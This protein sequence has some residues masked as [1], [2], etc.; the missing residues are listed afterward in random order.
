LGDRIQHSETAQCVGLQ[1]ACTGGSS[2]RRVKNQTI[3]FPLHVLGTNLGGWTVGCAPDSTTETLSNNVEVS[4]EP[5]ELQGSQSANMLSAST[6]NIE[7]IEGVSIKSGLLSDLIDLEKYHYIGFDGSD[8]LIIRQYDDFI[9]KKVSI[10]TGETT[11]IMDIST[12]KNHFIMAEI[13]ADDWVIW[14]ESFDRELH[15]G[16]STGDDWAIYAANIETKQ[17]IEIDSEKESFPKDRDFNAQPFAMSAKGNT[18][19]YTCYDSDES[20]VYIAIKLFDF[21]TEERRVII[22]QDD[23]SR[24][25]SMPSVGNNCVVFSDSLLKD[26]MRQDNIIYTYNLDDKTLSTISNDRDASLPVTCERYIAACV[27]EIDIEAGD[28]IVVY[29]IQEGRWIQEIDGS[30]SIYK[31]YFYPFYAYDMQMVESYLVWRGALDQAFY[32]YNIEDN[33]FYELFGKEDNRYLG[34]ILY[35]NDGLIVWA[36]D[37]SNSDDGRFSYVIL[38]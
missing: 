12:G 1:T 33:T 25:F 19:V 16:A 36:D 14:S 29:D 15:V 23:N 11:E 27:S 6:A 13:F 20:G 21:E 31:D 7:Q 28:H 9:I 34:Y 24:G 4:M 8:S 18:L 32:A 22:R 37:T 5:V 10:S 35:S 26:G 30:A 38:K 17:I 2:C 3:S